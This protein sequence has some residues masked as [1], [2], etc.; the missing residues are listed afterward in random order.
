MHWQIASEIQI[1]L[2]LSTL[3]LLETILH[4]GSTFII[5]DAIL[6]GNKTE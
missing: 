2:F 3:S 4:L 6:M 5:V 1:Q